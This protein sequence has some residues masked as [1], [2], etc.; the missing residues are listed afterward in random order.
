MFSNLKAFWGGS[1]DFECES[2]ECFLDVTNCIFNSSVAI[3]KG[4]AINYEYFWPSLEG[5]QFSNNWAIYGNDIG[6]YGSKIEINNLAFFSI[7][8]VGSS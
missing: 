4:G 1:I 6:S 5:N 2:E 8:N 3:L 7:S